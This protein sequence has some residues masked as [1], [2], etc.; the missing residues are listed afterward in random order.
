MFDHPIPHDSG[1][2][3]ALRSDALVRA[4]SRRGRSPDLRRG[5][6]RGP[7]EVSRLRYLAFQQWCWS[8]RIIGPIKGPRTE[9]H[10]SELQSLMRISYAVLRLKKNIDLQ[11]LLRNPYA[12]FVLTKTKTNNTHSTQKK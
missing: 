9:E 2:P 7:G 4:K 5:R 8:A 6:T 11:S 1:S 3:G 12:V 10:T